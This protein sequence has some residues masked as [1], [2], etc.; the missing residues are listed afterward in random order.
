M[1]AVVEKTGE[2]EGQNPDPDF[3]TVAIVHDGIMCSILHI[4]A[5]QLMYPDP[6]NKSSFSLP[7]AIERERERDYQTS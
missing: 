1:E 3:V 6:A 4:A 5:A 7:V 2:K